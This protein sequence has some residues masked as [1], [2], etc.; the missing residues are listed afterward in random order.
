MDGG[1]FKIGIVKYCGWM[2]ARKYTYCKSIWMEEW[3]DEWMD[4]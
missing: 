2:D 1:M 3:K 4:G